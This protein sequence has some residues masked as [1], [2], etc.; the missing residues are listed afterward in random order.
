MSVWVDR[1]RRGTAALLLLTLLWSLAGSCAE[2][3]PDTS[4]VMRQYEE[5]IDKIEPVMAAIARKKTHPCIYITTQD[6]RSIQSKEEYVPAV[7][8]VFNCPEDMRL[9]ATGG[10]RVRGNSTANDKSE[11]PYRI[12]FD[13]KQNLLGLHEG[14]AYKS[15]VL[16]RSFWNLVPDYMAFQLAKAIFGG[17]YYSSDCV[18][19]NLYINGYAQGVYLLCEQNQA[20]KGRMEVHEPEEGETGTDIGYLLEMDNYASDEHPYFSVP[21]RE[22]VTDIAGERRV[23]PSRNYSIKS[24]L[25]S[26]EQEEYIG[27]YLQ[28]VFTVLYEA[29][30]NGKKLSMDGNLDLCPGEGFET[31]SDAVSALIDLESLA[32]MAILEELTQD[33]DVGAGSFYLAVDFSKE[34][35][36]PKL[37]F[38]G[39]WDYNWGYTEDPQGGYY[40]LTFQKLMEDQWERSNVWFVLAMKLEGF[41]QIVRDKWKDLSDSGVLTETVRR[42]QSECESLAQDLDKDGWKLQN[43]LNIVRYVEK[44]IEWLD[45]QW[46]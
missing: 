8:N 41:E 45:K 44:R 43:G 6:R 39:P 25:R 21:G 32:N 28:G 38:L 46:K 5:R 26:K 30:A 29:A 10:V 18:F 42:V 12:K 34:S 17:K 23:I 22:E 20:A 11:K 1:F 31:P 4:E 3:I 9:T 15:W 7:I 37:T 35:L 36:Y 33:Y 27:K 2:E 14:K 24:D 13:K 19:V 40:A 16:L